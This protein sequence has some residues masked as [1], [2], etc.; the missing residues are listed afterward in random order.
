MALAE[1]IRAIGAHYPDSDEEEFL[2]RQDLDANR[3][4][5]SGLTNMLAYRL[6]KLD[7]IRLALDVLET[8]VNPVILTALQAEH[9]ADAATKAVEREKTEFEDSWR[10]PELTFSDAEVAEIDQP[11]RVAGRAAHAR[12]LAAFNARR[13][14]ALIAH[15]ELL[16]WDLLARQTVTREHLIRSNAY[17]ANFPLPT[18]TKADYNE[19]PDYSA[20]M[21][22]E[23]EANEIEIA[24]RAHA[25]ARAAKKMAKLRV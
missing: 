3:Q 6:T 1:E 22:A 24:G 17:L 8:H 13:A 15:H 14:E 7:A 18:A 19:P 21:I 16:D 2:S 20:D 10:H 25:A 23:H 12:L 4:F 11:D 9:D 5:H